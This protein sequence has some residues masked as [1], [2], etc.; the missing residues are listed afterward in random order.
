MLRFIVNIIVERINELRVK[1]G[2]SQNELA[3]KI[4]LSANAVYHWYKTDAMP[5]LANVERICEVMGITVEQ[6]F[7]GLGVPGE[8]SGDK[9]FLQEWQALSDQEKQAV[10]KGIEGFKAIREGRK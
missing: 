6:F 8:G 3:Q 1:K 5:T 7:S 2:W 4:G 9:S 10:V